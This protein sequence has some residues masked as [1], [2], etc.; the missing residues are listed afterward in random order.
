M[1]GMLVIDIHAWII[2]NKSFFSVD[3]SLAVIS[4]EWSF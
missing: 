3:V 1:N 4:M 2:T